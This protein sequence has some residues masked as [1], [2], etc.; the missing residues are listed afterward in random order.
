MPRVLLGE[1]VDRDDLSA[2]KNISENSNENML[3][4][5]AVKDDSRL[6]EVGSLRKDGAVRVSIKWFD[7]LGEAESIRQQ[8]TVCFRATK[9]NL[10]VKTARYSLLVQSSVG[11]R[12]AKSV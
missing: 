8:H 7:E 2:A 11:A 10:S 4:C 5:V 12:Y 1:T 9:I 6:V 3:Y